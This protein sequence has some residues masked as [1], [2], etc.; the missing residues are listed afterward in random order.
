MQIFDHVVGVPMVIQ[1]RART[2]DVPQI[3]Y[4]DKVVVVLVMS[5]RLVRTVQWV[6][7]TVAAQMQ[8]TDKVVGM[9]WWSSRTDAH[10]DAEGKHYF[11]TC[12]SIKP[13]TL[14]T[15]STRSVVSK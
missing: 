10:M 15:L 5:Q 12:F 1:R 3:E 14:E 11:Y 13:L 8:C 6:Q 7:N 4:F 9:E 2:V